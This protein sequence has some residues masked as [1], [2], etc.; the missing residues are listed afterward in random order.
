MKSDLSNKKRHM[1]KTAFDKAL[2]NLES[3]WQ[4]VRLDEFEI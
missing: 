3:H 1:N 4:N 2:A